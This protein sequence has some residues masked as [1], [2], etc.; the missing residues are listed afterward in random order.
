MK[1]R[2]I[3][4]S[5]ISVFLIV[6]LMIGS[7]Y[8][9]FNS[10]NVDEDLNV[11]KTGNLDVTYTLSEENITLTSNLP[12]ADNDVIFVKP[13]RIV[14]NNVGTVPYKF[15]LILTDATATNVIDYQYIMTKVGKLEAKPLADCTDNII[16]E[17]IILPADDSVVI[18]IRVYLSEN[19]QNTEIGKSFYANLRIDGLAV[20]N[21]NNDI[22]NSSLR[23]ETNV[24]AETFMKPNAISDE[25]IDFS[26]TSELSATNGI[27]L[28]S[29]TE[30]ETYPIYYYRGSVNNNLIFANT[31]WKAVRTT[32]TGGLKLLYNGMPTDGQCNNIGVSSQIGTKEFNL[33]FNSPAYVG[34][35]YSKPYVYNNKT[36]NTI[37]DTYYYGSD[38]TY[39]NGIYTL[40]DTISNSSWSSIYDGGLNNNHYTCFSDGTTCNS[41]YYIYYT[42]PTDA[43][44]IAL[45]DGKKI[46]DA[47]KEMFGV[48]KLN[49]DNN[50]ISSIIKGDNKTSRTLDY[51]Y[52]T[53]IE[54]GD[55]GSYVEDSV[56]CNDRDIFLLG[57]WNQK[58]GNT[59]EN[60]YFSAYNRLS[61]TY[62]P[63][64][65]CSRE[66]DAF[67][68]NE[69]IGNGNLDYPV[70]L[71]TTDEVMLAGGGD[72]KVNYSYYLYSESDYW[73]SSPMF[74]SY[75]S[76]SV[77]KVS[78]DGGVIG[79]GVN[80]NNVGVRPVITLKNGFSLIG[81]GD[82]TVLNPYVVK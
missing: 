49:D 15:N 48:D 10:S 59:L 62:E 47:L 33:E 76:A 64:L 77:Y 53:N 35:M 82:G 5:V 72:G 41:V 80:N 19:V 65:E 9:V 36:M 60:L 26:Q 46:E 28:R 56:W 52:Y 3:L 58:S 13:Y 69:V 42:N 39:E 29:G 43:Y 73:T 37:T 20:Y 44:Y 6:I 31:C 54:Q 55:Y 67:T 63:N 70:G 24:F 12:V 7:T 79:E 1:K 25:S 2:L 68:V 45:T 51:W 50:L 34:Y 74:L 78:R 14:I 61:R 16:K 11:Y 21:D 4:T 22:D 57:G 8:S 17:G 18:D 40:T 32:N 30:D 66:V 81:N 27:Y 71:L 38:V 23:I 75:D